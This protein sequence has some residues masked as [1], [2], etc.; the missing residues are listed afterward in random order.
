MAGWKPKHTIQAQIL[1]KDPGINN[2]TLWR[3]IDV[4]EIMQGRATKMTEGLEYLSY[5]E[6]LRAGIV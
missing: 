4:L 2:L 5:E 6:R 3:D 1:A